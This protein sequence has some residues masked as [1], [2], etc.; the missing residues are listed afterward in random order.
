[1]REKEKELLKYLKKHCLGQRNAVGG[2]RLVKVP[3]QRDRAAE[4]GPQPAGKRGAYLQRPHR[5]LLPRKQRGGVYH[6]PSA[7][8]DG[9]RAADGILG[10]DPGHGRLPSARGR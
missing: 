2:E 6:N 3:Y 7:P 5:L 1:M 8:K 4:A 10:H 9:A